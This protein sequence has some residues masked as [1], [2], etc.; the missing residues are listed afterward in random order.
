MTGKIQGLKPLIMWGVLMELLYLA[1][2]FF[3]SGQPAVAWF[4]IVHI[5]GW[6]LLLIRFVF[7]KTLSE[8][9]DRRWLSIAIGFG[10]VFRLTLVPHDIVAS[11]DIFRYVWDGRVG[12]SGENPFRYAPIDSA[13]A[14]LQ[15]DDLPKRIN[16]P[17]MRTIY[18]PLAQVFFI[19]SNVLFGPSISGMKLLFVLFDILTMIMLVRLLRLRNS[20]P[21]ALLLYAWSPLPVLYIGLDGHLDALGISFLVLFLLFLSENKPARGACALGAAAL[22]KLY[23]MMVAPFL[24]W[25]EK[26][27]RKVVVVMIPVAML[28]VGTMFYIEPTGGLLESFLVFNS[29]FEFNGSIFKLLLTMLQ[30]NELAHTVSAILLFMT[31]AAVFFLRRPILEKVFLAF[32]GFI[33]FSASVQPWYLLW[34]NALLVLRW[35][36]AVFVLIGTIGLSNL[37]VYEYVGS[38]V[39]ADQSWI[40]LLEY[41]PFFVLAVLELMTSR[42]RKANA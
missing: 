3:P 36:R 34:L 12:L 16:H 42:R 21:N 28:G 19:A 18:P 14:H 27:W 32:V 24:F 1:F 5:V 38:G 25:E 23:P 6:L 15:T 30:S 11:D 40:L 7:T 2:Y 35:S 10:I 29:A 39:W 13:V 37:V 33:V 31:L 8:K 41:I 9:I 20:S 26:G 22:A 4:T 17:E